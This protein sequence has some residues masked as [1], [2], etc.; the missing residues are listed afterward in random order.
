MHG[1]D[2][3]RLSRICRQEIARAAEMAATMDMRHPP[4][5]AG[6]LDRTLISVYQWWGGLGERVRM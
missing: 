3:T 6:G 1:K 2:L 5:S 4:I